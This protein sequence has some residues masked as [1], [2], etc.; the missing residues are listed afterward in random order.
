MGLLPSHVFRNILFFFVLSIPC[1]LFCIGGLWMFCFQ[2]SS[3]HKTWY[4]GCQC[5][6]RQNYFIIQSI[7][8]LF[9][10]SLFPVG[11]SS[12][13]SIGYHWIEIPIACDY[14]VSN[15]AS[16]FL[17]FPIWSLLSLV[18]LSAKTKLS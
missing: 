8:Y 5:W 4:P 3:L 18:T 16:V 7:Q 9:F 14:T 15:A 17:L 10:Y 13:S 2:Q 6:G 12:F 11:G 1:M